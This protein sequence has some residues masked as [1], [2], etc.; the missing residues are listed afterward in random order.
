[1]IQKIKDGESSSGEDDESDEDWSSEE[2]QPKN[3]K[4]VE[5]DA[6]GFEIVKK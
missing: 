2:E 4:K 3:Q 1:M 6:D 5:L